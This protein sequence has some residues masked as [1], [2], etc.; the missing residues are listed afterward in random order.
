MAAAAHSTLQEAH[1]SILP[2]GSWNPPNSTDIVNASNCSTVTEA[3]EATGGVTSDGRLHMENR[4]IVIGSS[5]HVKM[6]VARKV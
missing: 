6:S 3:A 5:A 2:S 4:C 1:L